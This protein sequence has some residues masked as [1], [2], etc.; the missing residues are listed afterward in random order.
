MRIPTLLLSILA[1]CTGETTDSVADTNDSVDSGTTDTGD[2][3]PLDCVGSENSRYTSIQNAVDESEPGDE[4]VVCDGIY[5]ESVNFSGKELTLNAETPGHVTFDGQGQQALMTFTNDSYVTFNDI[6][7]QSGKADSG[8]ALQL[9]SSTVVLRQCHF[10]GNSASNGGAIALFNGSLLSLDTSNF[11]DN[12]A[13]YGGA[14]YATN[15]SHVTDFSTAGSAFTSNASS[16]TGSLVY[17]DQSSSFTETGVGA[18]LYTDNSCNAGAA[19]GIGSASSASI[20][21]ATI[22]TENDCEMAFDLMVSGASILLMPEITIDGFSTDIQIAD[23]Q[24]AFAEGSEVYCSYESGC[25]TL[26]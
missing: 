1:G 14:I 21:T 17:L 20:N 22:S 19:F 25:I 18:M 9:D 24:Y 16:I 7:F 5:S 3:S 23:S 4:I 10:T 2:S 8:G 15:N 13:D 6:K 12:Q 26:N 11:E